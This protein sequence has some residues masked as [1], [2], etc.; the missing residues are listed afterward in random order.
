[1]K[2]KRKNK[3]FFSHHEIKWWSVA[4]SD[5]LEKN[6]HIKNKFISV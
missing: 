2:K 3:T 1:M 6:I 5:F 4:L